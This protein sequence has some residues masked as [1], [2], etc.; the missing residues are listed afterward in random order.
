MTGKTRNNINTEL[1]GLKGYSNNDCDFVPV[2]G[3]NTHLKLIAF[4]F[5]YHVLKG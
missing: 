2:G 4:N 1:F 5:A 3:A